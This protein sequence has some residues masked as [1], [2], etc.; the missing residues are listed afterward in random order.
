MKKGQEFAQALNKTL[1]EIEELVKSMGV[2]SKD[3]DEGEGDVPPAPEGDMPPAPEG[4]VPPAPE[5]DADQDVVHEATEGDTDEMMQE[6]ASL[7]DEQLQELLEALS[8]EA[9]K[10]SSAGAP[11]GGEPPMAPPAAPGA[12]EMERSIKSEF[13]NLKKSLSDL[14][15]EISKLRKENDELK[16]SRR[17][18]A[19]P[20]LTRTVEAMQKSGKASTVGARL[21][22]SETQEYLLGQIRNKNRAVTSADVASVTACRTEDELHQVQDDLKVRGIALPSK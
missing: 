16:K 11:A 6:I 20:A 13:A 10:R 12:E 21:S 5:G 14:Q 9:A 2:M 3:E 18:T 1:S 19:K 4:D 22:K 8:Q 15:G 7:S 17:V